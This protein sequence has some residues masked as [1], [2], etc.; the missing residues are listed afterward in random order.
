MSIPVPPQRTMLAVLLVVV[1]AATVGVGVSPLGFSGSDDASRQ[2]RVAE[3]SPGAAGAPSDSTISP[4]DRANPQVVNLDDDLLKAVQDAARAAK[5]DDVP[6]WITSGWRS[7][8]RQQELLDEATAS[9]GSPRAA[10]RLVSTPASAR[11][12]SGHAVDIGPDD[13]AAWLS[14]H[15][16]KLGLCRVSAQE[17]WHFELAPAGGRCPKSLPDVDD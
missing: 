9:S 10:R 16:E 15:G 14:E 5:A 6:F 3:A 17:T 2:P 7:R 4:F 11:H 8:A 12:V 13:A 1:L